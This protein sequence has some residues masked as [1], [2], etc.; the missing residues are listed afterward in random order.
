M[1]TIETQFLRQLMQDV[2]SALD[3][4][5]TSDHISDRRNLLRTMMSA[6][7]GVTWVYRNY[8]FSIAKEMEA[9][10]PLMEMAY[11]EASFQVTETGEIVPQPRFV[12]LPAAIRMATRTAHTLNPDV[13]V[14]F[15]GREW[16]SLRKAILL[17]NRI[18]HPKK[19]DDLLVY[20][21][22]ISSAKEGFFWLLDMSITVMDLCTKAFSTHV[23][24]AKDFLTRLVAG[25]PG[26]LDLYDQ[27]HR[28]D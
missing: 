11:A 3:A 16:S 15:G 14:D 7:E 27:A 12:T 18:T 23:E 9:S 25:D 17:R 5:E 19:L 13:N 4:L 10:D 20:E 26:A 8:V 28:E 24:E 2:Q 22:D 1:S 21:D 6:A